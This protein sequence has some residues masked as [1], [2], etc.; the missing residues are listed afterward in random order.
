MIRIWGKNSN[1]EKFIGEGIFNYRALKVYRDEVILADNPFTAL[2][3]IQKD[4]KNAVYLSND[5]VKVLKE[6]RVKIAVIPDDKLKEALL[7]EGVGVKVV[8]CSLS[9]HLKENI[10][11]AEVFNPEQIEEDFT[12]TREGHK[13]EFHIGDVRYILLGVKEGFVS[14]LKCHI[15]IEY[16]GE[17]FLDNIDLLSFHSRSRFSQNVSK[18]LNLETQLIEKQIL[19]I[20]KYLEKEQDKLSVSEKKEYKLTDDEKQ[21]GMK[22]LKSKHIFKEIISDLE[23]FYVGEELN[24]LLLYLCSTSRKMDYPISALIISASAS[25]K[26]FLT[27][28][29]KNLTPAEDVVSVSSLSEQALNY[30]EEDGLLNKFLI[31]G[32]FVHTKE[33][34][35]QL[36]EMLSA[37]QLCRLIT[38][39]DEKTG[40]MVAR[41]IVRKVVVSS[42]MTTTSMKINPENASRM[43]V[44]NQDETQAQ[45]LKIHKFQYGKYSFNRNKLKRKK[46]L[47][48]KK[49]QSAQRLLTKR[50]I[51]NPYAKY[52]S[53]PATL[54]RTRRDNERF[55]DLIASCC[56][57]RQFQKE[58]KTFTDGDE[59]IKYIECDLID[60]KW[61]YKIFTEK[62]AKSILTELTPSDVKLYEAIR[63]IAQKQAKQNNLKITEI[64]FSQREI[65]DRTG[66]GQ[67]W[68]REHL[69]RLVDFEYVII[70]KGGRN[71]SKNTYRLF[72]DE[73]I[74]KLDLSV[75]PTPEKIKEMIE[76]D[77]NRARTEQC[78]LL[79]FNSLY[80]KNIKTEHGN[81]RGR[82]RQKK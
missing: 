36:R 79:A 77:E 61:A 74:T 10:E 60:Y 29:V 58:E 52:L 15:R 64:H 81:F 16:Q 34:E 39:K 76:K 65:R 35:Y 67:S 55:V 73:D 5:P 37:Q 38:I 24:K 66:L 4:F 49:H 54:M 26:S 21:L 9:E 2:T 78:S 47:I 71:G 30:I 31:L 56:F 28:A 33:V 72:A 32:E 43:F 48:I 3:L 57:L 1:K 22:F 53:F 70:V 44:I 20:I 6:A 17:L 82:E 8:P 41:K 14:S 7:K 63:N 42:V 46:E 62:L 23:Y 12:A 69:R 51:V 59:E 50:T 18:M 40:K 75:I 13:Y 80:Y 19:K 68:V 11:K 27:D 45:T 25:G